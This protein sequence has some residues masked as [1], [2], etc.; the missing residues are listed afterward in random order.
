MS[1][2]DDFINKARTV[3][4]SRRDFLKVSMVGIAGSVV[5][6]C[7]AKPGTP[8]ANTA[9]PTTV[10]ASGKPVLNIA[11]WGGQWLETLKAEIVTPFEKEFDCTVNVDTAYPFWPKMAAAPLDQPPLDLINDNLPHSFRMQKAGMLFSPDEIKKKIAHPENYWPFAFRG[12]GVIHG[13]SPYGIA[14]RKDLV[15]PPPTTYKELFEDPKFDG[16][17]GTYSMPNTLGAALVMI[18]SRL[19][20]KDDHDFEAGLAALH[21]AAPWKLA[22]FTTQM[23]GLLERGEILVANIHDADPFQQADQGLPFGWN[24]ATDSPTG[25]LAQNI[26]VSKYTKYPDLAFAFLEYYLDPVRHFKLC[27]QFYMR[28]GNKTEEVTAKMA[29]LGVKNSSDEI[30]NLWVFDWL[31]WN[32]NEE[33][34]V[35]KYNEI[36]QG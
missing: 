20:G 1:T 26:S 17:R 35:E 36:I 13:W 18:A 9:A 34:I 28:P 2:N 31:W 6:G 15:E 33:V 4:L 24:R 23:T 3:Q 21:K 19:W 5:A 32:E 27:G 7:A 8:V 12:T 11:Q 29:A 16:K 14:Y 25:V 22:E 10:T 30:D